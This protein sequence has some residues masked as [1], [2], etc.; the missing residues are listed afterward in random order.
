M[1]KLVF[2]LIAALSVALT[3]CSAFESKPIEPKI[4]GTTFLQEDKGL[5]FA[6][7]DSVRYAPTIIYTGEKAGR[8]AVEMKVKPFVGMQVTVF[9]SN[10]HQEPVFFVGKATVKQIEKYYE[11]NYIFSIIIVGT[12][13]MVVLSMFVLYKIVEREAAKVNANNHA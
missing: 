7:F 3:G 9:T 11:V 10:I 13:L 6:E 12:L 4:I 2:M 1:K 8:D 5:I